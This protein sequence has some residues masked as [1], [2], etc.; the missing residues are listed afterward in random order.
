MTWKLARSKPGRGRA[1]MQG[2][3][4]P[5]GRNHVSPSGAPSHRRALRIVLTPPPP[6]PSP[7]LPSPLP[8]PHT[9]PP[10][11]SPLP[12][13]SLPSPPPPPPSPLSP[14]PPSPLPSPLSSP[15]PPFSPLPL[16][17][18]LSPLPLPLPLPPPLS[19]S[20]LSPLPSPLSPLPLPS[21]SPLTA[22]LGEQLMYF[23]KSGPM[24]NKHLSK[25]SFKG[26][27]F[28]NKNY[29]QRYF[30]SLSNRKYKYA[31]TCLQCVRCRVRSACLNTERHKSI[32]HKHTLT[33]SGNCTAACFLLQ[34]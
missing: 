23:S 24:K 18:P 1:E 3:S 27:L 33:S 4:V 5:L 7:P 12:L 26:E 2:S 32:N 10:S 15:P 31:S 6:P 20:P 30:Y 29:S 25:L 14:S 34:Y 16:P 22:P 8:P 21:P 11:L 13:P 17:S 19:P 28:F 9:S